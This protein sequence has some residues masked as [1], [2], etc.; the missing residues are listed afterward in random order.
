MKENYIQNRFIELADKCYYKNIPVYTEFLNLN[1]QSIFMSMIT[2]LPP[3]QYQLT[4]GY[5]GAERC[6]AAF[7]PI[8]YKKVVEAPISILKVSPVH[9]KYADCLTHRDYLGAVMNLGIE[10]SMIGDILVEQSQTAYLFVVD[11]ICDYII[12]QLLK[13]KHTNVGLTEVMDIDTEITPDFKIIEGTVAS[14]RLDSVAALAFGIPRSRSM[15][16]IESG[17]VFVGG[18]NITSNAYLLKNNDIISI[19][20]LG[21][22]IYVG[23]SSLTR[24]GRLLITIK[25]YV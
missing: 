22:F 5:Q 24:K 1:E 9:M 3:V 7:T 12:E 23:Q 13:I 21:R 18:K 25:K 10:R 15:K 4:G 17:L 16:Y 2:K 11:K 14:I 6:M 20:G 8:D 19:R